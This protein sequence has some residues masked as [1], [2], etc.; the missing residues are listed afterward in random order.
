MNKRPTD[1]TDSPRHKHT[2]DGSSPCVN[3]LLSSSWHLEE[4]LH[5]WAAWAQASSISPGQ[6]HHSWPP[7]SLPAKLSRMI[8]SKSRS[9]LVTAASTSSPAIILPFHLKV[10]TNLTRKW[11]G[12]NSRAHATGL[13][14]PQ[15]SSPTSQLRSWAPLA[16]KPGMFPQPTVLAQ[17]SPPC[18]CHPSNSTWR[19]TSSGKWPPLTPHPLPMVALPPPYNFLS[20]PFTWQVISLDFHGCLMRTTDDI[21]TAITILVCSKQ[22]SNNTFKY[23]NEFAWLFL[24]VEPGKGQILQSSFYRKGRS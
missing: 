20:H 11:M 16:I 22:A 3:F 10:T 12:D 2:Q 1:K 15:S 21:K 9:D 18:C 8:F 13:A 5:C 4:E 19:G 7:R 24:R 6:Q 14:L 23:I 17:P